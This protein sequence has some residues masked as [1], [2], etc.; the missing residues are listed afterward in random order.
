MAVRGE[1]LN[2]SVENSFIQELCEGNG[3]IERIKS[4][5]SQGKRVLNLYEKVFSK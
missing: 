1:P 3:F 5:V 4:E 2:K